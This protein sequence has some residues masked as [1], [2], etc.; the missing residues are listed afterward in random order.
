MNAGTSDDVVMAP[1]RTL[2]N[3]VNPFRHLR[4]VPDPAA[5]SRTDAATAHLVRVASGDQDAFA[6]LYD[7]LGGLV[8][9]IVERVVRNRALAE[10][11]TQE[12]FLDVWRLAG[13]FDPDRGSAR[14]WVATMAHRRSVDRVR[15]EEASRSRDDRVG[16]L[17]PTHTEEVADQVG[18]H[19]DRERVRQA[20]DRL[21]LAQRQTIELAYFGGHSY[22]Q[23]AVL[24]DMPE[25]TVKTRI[26]DGLIRL[27][28]ILGTMS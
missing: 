22:R 26:R 12:V 8:F 7:E 23:V 24:L 13:R 28:D 15:S 14:S 2:T 21:T 4:S 11:I 20:L 5:P 27:R 3:D 19:L 9:G 17:E 16:R 1:G 18:D 25:G 10:E 6:G